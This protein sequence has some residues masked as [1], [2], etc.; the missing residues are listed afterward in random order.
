M[1]DEAR[2]RAKALVVKQMRLGRP[3]QEAAAEAGLS[4]RRVTAYC[5]LQRGRLLGE[6]ALSENTSPYWSW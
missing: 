1:E 5:L 2:R 6:S 3:W 4:M